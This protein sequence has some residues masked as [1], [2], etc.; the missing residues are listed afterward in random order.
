TWAIRS[1]RDVILDPAVGL[2]VFLE[3][4]VERLVELG[5][6]TTD[7]TQQVEG[8]EISPAVHDLARLSL[9]ALTSGLGSRVRLGDYSKTAGLRRPDAVICNPPYTRH[10]HLGAEWKEDQRGRIREI[11][12]AN[13]SRFSSL[14]VYF[15]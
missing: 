4:S 1:T 11:F 7:A 13:I 2:G 8:I 5:A 6:S 9:E 3:A 15:F 12:G 10:H 14:F